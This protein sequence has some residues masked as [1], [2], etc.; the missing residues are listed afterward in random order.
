MVG[1]IDIL[2]PVPWGF[3]DLHS[4]RPLVR[5]SSPPLWCANVPQR[6]VIHVHLQQSRTMAHASPA[7]LP[8]HHTSINPSIPVSP[9]GCAHVPSSMLTSF[10]ECLG[11]LGAKGGHL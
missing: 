3:A 4:H 7:L 5:T 10:G 11:V 8:L 6:A 1:Q 2:L 9:T